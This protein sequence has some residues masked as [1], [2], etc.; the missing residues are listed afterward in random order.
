LFFKT[1]HQNEGFFVFIGAA[2]SLVLKRVRFAA[3]FF[4]MA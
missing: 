3:F 2:C 1:L 4:V